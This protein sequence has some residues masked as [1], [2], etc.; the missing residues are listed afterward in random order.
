MRQLRITQ[1][2]TN[3]NQESLSKYFKEVSM[4]E[5]ISADEEAIL[6]EKIQEGDQIALH[7]LTK[8]NL[9]FVVSVAKQFENGNN[10][11]SLGDLIN[12][13]NLGL[14]KAASKFDASRGFKF[15]S[16]AVWWIRQSIM[17]A[18]S[19]KSRVIRPPMNKIAVYSKVMRGYSKLEQEYEREPTN[20][21]LSEALELSEDEI[22]ASMKIGHK[23]ASFDAPLTDSEDFSL[24]DA[25]SNNQLGDT[26]EH[27]I[28]SSFKLDIQLAMSKLSTREAEVI[29]KF[30]GLNDTASMTLDSISEEMNISKERVRQIK[31]KALENL[32][33]N[34]EIRKLLCPHFSN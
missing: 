3:R 11:L 27:L 17:S 1:K 10:G 21:E 20:E 29:I 33:N 7:K 14:L 23:P 26:D 18:I 16:Y 6:A 19:Q 34:T 5:M 13:G 15:I 28:R 12:E 2:I 22:T 4:I 9:R 8:A 30:F 31:T 24:L 25:M 32:S